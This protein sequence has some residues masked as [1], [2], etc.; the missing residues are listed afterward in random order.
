MPIADSHNTADSNS[1]NITPSN[2]N[3][4]CIMLP[5]RDYLEALFD[6]T[7]RHLGDVYDPIMVDGELTPAHAQSLATRPAHRLL[8][9]PPVCAE[10][11][12]RLGLV[13][14]APPGANPLA[15]SPAVL[16]RLVQTLD[17]GESISVHAE[18]EDAIDAVC[19]YVNP[20]LGGG[21]A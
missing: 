12:D 14:M 2:N 17:A 1:D 5:N 21:H 8:F 9:N 20:W 3:L 13:W 7:G 19:S 16:P 18:T 4:V 15:V 6:A 11:F 10:P